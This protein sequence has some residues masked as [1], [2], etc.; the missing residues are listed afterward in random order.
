MQQQTGPEKLR[1]TLHR[2]TIDG[3][4]WWLTPMILTSL[5]LIII[6]LA[7]IGYRGQEFIYTLF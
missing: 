5:L 3:R 4:K 1:E 2:L 7:L 6:V